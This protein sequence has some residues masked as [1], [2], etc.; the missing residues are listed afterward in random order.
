MTTLVLVCRPRFEVIPN[1][2]PVAASF[3]H[4][5][6]RDVDSRTRIH[7]FLRFC[8]FLAFKPGHAFPYARLTLVSGGCKWEHGEPHVWGWEGVC[9]HLQ[10]ARLER[11]LVIMRAVLPSRL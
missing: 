6:P 4:S 9:G 8:S 10:R 2:V 1:V 11:D 7:G 5:V 3:G